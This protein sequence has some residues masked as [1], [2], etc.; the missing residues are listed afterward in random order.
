MQ[1]PTKSLKVRDEQDLDM[2]VLA[3]KL[4]LE[5]EVHCSQYQLNTKRSVDNCVSA[6]F[7]SRNI[8]EKSV[9]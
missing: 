1:L 3:C 5:K 8:F 6:V 2:S 4:N 9:I 7:Q